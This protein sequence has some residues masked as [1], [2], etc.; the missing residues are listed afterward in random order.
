MAD[1]RIHTNRILHTRSFKLKPGTFTS[2]GVVSVRHIRSLRERIRY[3]I[4]DK[5]T[6]WSKV[7]YLG[8]HQRETASERLQSL[9]TSLAVTG[10]TWRDSGPNGTI[11]SIRT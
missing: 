2:T 7:V 11:P 5:T 8:I 6:R 9:G 4:S 3:K 10:S 1:E